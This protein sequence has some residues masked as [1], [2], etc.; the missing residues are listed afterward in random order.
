MLVIPAFWLFLSLMF[1]SDI[2]ILKNGKNLPCDEYTVADGRVT[3][4]ANGQTFSIPEKLVDWD[5]S[6]KA[7]QAL[8]KKQNDEAKADA[9]AKKA[10]RRPPEKRSPITLTTKDLNTKGRSATTGPVTIKFRMSGNSI[11]VGMTFNDK[12]PFDFVLDTGASITAI[13]PDILKEAGITPERE[14]IPIVGIGGRPIQARACK[15]PKLALNDATVYN[16]KATSYRIS[17]LYNSGF[18]GLIGQ[19]FLNHFVMQLDAST[20]TLTLT[21]TGTVPSEMTL[22]DSAEKY[23]HQKTTNKLEKAF[24]VIEANVR[25]AGQTRSSSE[26]N[27][28]IRELRQVDRELL[29]VKQQ[30]RYQKSALRAGMGSKVTEKERQSMENLSLCLPKADLFVDQVS[31]LN[32]ALTQMINQ[33]EPNQ[34]TRDNLNHHL[35]KTDKAWHVLKS[36]YD[37]LL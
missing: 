2:L 29:D 19:D 17:S 31:V 30:L 32:R 15:V 24:K 34:K 6:R 9:K 35:T 20:K 4:K 12:G 36:C 37:G 28:I 3:I 18:Y 5:A 25:K 13:D 1:Q 11:I 14:I 23:D 7:K 16:M 21:P 22:M 10:P 33:R 8:V 26:T 27:R